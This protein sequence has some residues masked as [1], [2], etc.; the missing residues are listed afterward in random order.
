[1]TTLYGTAG[2]AY[3]GPVRVLVIPVVVACLSLAARPASA[4]PGEVIA[5]GEEADDPW[6]YD[7][8]FVRVVTDFSFF[9]GSQVVNGMDADYFGMG[10]TFAGEVRVWEDLWVEAAW[11]FPHGSFT[12]IFDPCPAGP[13]PTEPCPFG[14]GGTRVGNPYLGASYFVDA[15][16][17]RLTFGLGFTIPVSETPAWDP[18]DPMDLDD[19]AKSLADLLVSRIE[20]NVRPWLY[21]PRAF[22]IVARGRAESVGPLLLAADLALAPMF[23]TGTGGVYS[24]DTEFILVPA[25]D[26]GWRPTPWLSLGLRGQV[27]VL[28]TETDEILGSIEPFVEAQKRDV[29][30]FRLGFLL[31]LGG[32]NGSTFDDDGLWALRMTAG[33]LF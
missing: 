14:G 19:L 26:V 7:R 15:R 22:S 18:T 10:F 27:A 9:T 31:H 28:P 2:R 33:V 8:P 30:Y 24:G 6:A 13:M 3:K 29:G 1:M 32:P 23:A 12:T 5:E 16:P 21:L 20:G 17:V 25:A 4:Q 11:G